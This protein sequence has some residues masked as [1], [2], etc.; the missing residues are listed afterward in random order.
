MP[1]GLTDPVGCVTDGVIGSVGGEA[2]SKL[3]VG[4]WESIC[5]SFADAMT[6]LLKAFA[7]AFASMPGP[8]LASNGVRSVY[9]ISLGIAASVACLLVIGQVIRTVF[10]HDGRPLAAAAVGLG[11]AVMAFLLTL[12]LASTALLASDE[13]TR[14]IVDNTI[15]GQQ[16]L[17]DKLSKLVAWNPGQSAS[18]LLILAVLGILLTIVLWFEMLLRGAAIM[19]LIATSPIAAVGQI[20]DSTKRWWSQLVGM[21]IQL[22][23]L[24]V[25]IAMVFSLGFNLA[26]DSQDLT[27]TLSG[28]LVLLLAALAW[29]A[30]ARF[31]TFASVQVG[32]GAGLAALLGF[33][34]GQLA[35]AGGAASGPTP[36]TFGQE[37]AS[38]TMAGVE[39]R[40]GV[41]GAGAGGA[42][43]VGGAA[44]KLGAVGAGVRLA[45]QAVNSLA[46]GMEKMA[47]HAGASGANAFAAQPAGYV[48]RYP[49]AQSGA[50]PRQDQPVSET[51][52]GTALAEP[53]APS[54][55]QA[56]H[57]HALH[58]ATP[59]LPVASGRSD[60]PTIEFAPLPAGPA[61]SG[62]T[63][64]APA[65]PPPTSPFSG[66]A[67]A[68]W[69][70]TSQAGAPQPA[71]SAPAQ[72]PAPAPKPTSATSAP[73]PVS[74]PTANTSPP[75][76]QAPAATPQPA[77]APA[78]QPRP[79]QSRPPAV[80]PADPAPA[81]EPSTGPA[82]QPEG[83]NAS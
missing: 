5:K 81:S 62:A 73:L 7:A 31:F 83:G 21:T 45:Q 57:Q 33:A 39:S 71:A 1:C 58:E 75:A 9:A 13:M 65:A 60:P 63:P 74:G 28:M 41:P 36:D 78:P 54:A 64:G 20:S 19:A 82:D 22:I 18:L 70:S 56:D 51:D 37:T 79:E 11:K 66:P 43:A 30:V 23:F 72:A 25:V 80:Q 76:P 10:T 59:E 29:P 4:A 8:D 40:G 34:G 26:G 3:A 46:Q 67:A 6:E 2:V 42:G 24:K 49:S 16:Q 61:P 52:Q 50:G 53:E 32:G 69:S 27:T 12:V 15:G 35:T 17:S 68:S 38:R 14:Y 44:G 55:Q 47:G 77:P 48:H